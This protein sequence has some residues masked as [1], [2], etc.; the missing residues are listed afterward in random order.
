MKGWWRVISEIFQEEMV[1]MV[2]ESE[3]MTGVVPKANETEV[4]FTPD[5]VKVPD[6]IASK[7]RW[8]EEVARKLTSVR[9]NS[10]DEEMSA[11]TVVEETLAS[12]NTERSVKVSVPSLVMTAS[13]SVLSITLCSSMNELTEEEAQMKLSVSSLVIV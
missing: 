2:T 13:D 7:E 12:R 5:A 8:M 9:A 3:R 11:V 4:T 10:E 1:A 6:V